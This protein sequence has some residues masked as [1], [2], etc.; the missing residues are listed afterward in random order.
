MPM[1]EVVFELPVFFFLSFYFVIMYS[2]ATFTS[3]YNIDTYSF[4]VMACV[5][6]QVLQNG[7]CSYEFHR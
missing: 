2:Y 4:I 1:Q 6:E 5:V 7:I 3:L